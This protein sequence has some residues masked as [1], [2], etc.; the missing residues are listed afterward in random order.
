MEWRCG[1]GYGTFQAVWMKMPNLEPVQ[2][3]QK[4]NVEECS[5]CKTKCPRIVTKSDYKCPTKVLLQ[6]LNMLSAH[7]QMAHLSFLKFTTSRKPSYQPTTIGDYSWK[8]PGKLEP[9]TQW[10]EFDRSLART[11]FFYQSSRLWSALPLSVKSSKYKSTFKKKC[12]AWV[13]GNIMTKP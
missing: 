12:K 8:R 1:S 11:H 3:W 5:Y 7:Q 9:I 6:K 4:K 2:A 13:T 10:T